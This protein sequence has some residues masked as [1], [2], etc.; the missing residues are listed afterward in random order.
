MAQHMGHP[1]NIN[2]ACSPWIIRVILHVRVYVLVPGTS[3][4]SLENNTARP[5][6]LILYESSHVFTCQPVLFIS[7][8]A[9]STSEEPQE[10]VYCSL[11]Y[12]DMGSENNTKHVTLQSPVRGL[13]CRY[14]HR[15][16]RCRSPVIWRWGGGVVL[17]VQP[18][19]KFMVPLGGIS[20]LHHV[21]GELVKSTS[22]TILTTSKPPSLNAHLCFCRRV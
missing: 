15:V 3:H 2:L 18:T 22:N 20:G 13:S 6:P 11:E 14:Q 4:C 7:N 8:L 17:R 12:T 16:Y 19:G 1:R 21:T 5:E 9:T 10:K